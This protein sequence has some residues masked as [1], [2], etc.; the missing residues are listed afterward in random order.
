MEQLW[1]FLDMTEESLEGKDEP[2]YSIYE[3]LPDDGPLGG[4]GVSNGAP[5]PNWE[6]IR[7]KG[8][9]QCLLMFIKHMIKSGAMVST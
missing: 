3:G 6:A 9:M 4:G 8:C 5:N 2:G 7:K 1:A